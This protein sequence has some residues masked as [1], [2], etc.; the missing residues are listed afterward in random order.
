MP[1][2]ARAAGELDDQIDTTGQKHEKR[3]LVELAVM[4][5]GVAEG[6]VSQAD[7]KKQDVREAEHVVA[8]HSGADPDRRLRKKKSQRARQDGGANPYGNRD[9]V[10]SA[11][12]E[13]Q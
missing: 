3:E 5:A 13:R 6:R 1:I 4:F 12:R 9:F 2:R 8:A 7:K 10:D 11:G